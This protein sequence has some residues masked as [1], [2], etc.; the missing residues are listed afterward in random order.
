MW[1]GGVDF[2]VDGFFLEIF[3]EE[4]D[5]GFLFGRFLGILYDCK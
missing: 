4:G 2:G 1:F 3:V 5:G